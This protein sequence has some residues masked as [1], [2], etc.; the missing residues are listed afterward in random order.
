MQDTRL[1]QSKPASQSRW[2][3][4]S[5]D[6]PQGDAPAEDGWR[7]DLAE[8]RARL[9]SLDDKIHDLL[10]ERAR[11]VEGVA[12]SG[13][14]AAFRPGREASILRRLLSRHSGKLPP[15][16]LG[17]MWREMLAGTTAMQ[18]SIAVAVFDPEP[19][20]AIAAIAREHFGCLTP[21]LEQRSTEAALTALRS[22][23]A[24]VAVL[25]FPNGRDAWWGLLTSA[26]PRLHIV[27]RL[28]FWADRPAHVANAD[29][30]VI[31]TAAPDS[32]GFDR[33]FIALPRAADRGALSDAGLTPHAMHG[34]VAEVEGMVAE[35]DPRL[36]AG[37][38]VLGGYAVPVAG[39]AA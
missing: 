22:G 30:L 8:L 18:T 25:P 34:A 32:S 17:R 20:G 26:E 19:T 5:E 35:G 16:T 27:A 3:A 36:P 12:R 10:M 38:I 14:S 11:V 37:A 21:L 13:K 4:P 39:E 9:D 24:S 2:D 28:P 31:A 6:A 7:P 33:S 15:Q 29:S 23:C 1:P